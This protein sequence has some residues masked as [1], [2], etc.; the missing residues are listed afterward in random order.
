MAILRRH[1]FEPVRQRGDHV[2]MQRRSGRETMTTVVPDH[3][4]LAPGT[5]SSIIRQSRLSRED[6]GG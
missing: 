4:R 5:L 2:V 1:G 6:F 3:K